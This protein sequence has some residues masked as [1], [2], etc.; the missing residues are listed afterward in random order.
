MNGLNELF[1]N[2]NHEIEKNV[3]DTVNAHNNEIGKLLLKI[4]VI[5]QAGNMVNSGCNEVIKEVENDITNSIIFMAQAFYRNSM[6][7]LR[8]AI[9]LSLSYIYFHDHNYEYLLWKNNKVDMSWAKLFDGAESVVNK[10]YLS[11][12]ISGELKVEELR[13][14][15]KKCYHS[16]SEYVHGKYM[17]MQSIN[18]MKITYAEEAVREYFE[19]VNSVAD[20]MILLMFVRFGRDYDLYKKLD[21]KIDIWNP[22]VKK[23]GG[24]WK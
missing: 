11:L 13:D 3:D 20:I 16:C 1:I 8:S 9:E 15:I 17:Y 10:Q 6:M 4:E 5:Q 18:E 7:C 23:Y 14:K 21:D 19:Q 22:I 24:E 2:I 12:F